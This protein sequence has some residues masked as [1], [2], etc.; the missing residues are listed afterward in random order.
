MAS[1]RAEQLAD[2]LL[3][4]AEK[5]VEGIS[6]SVQKEVTFEIATDDVKLAAQVLVRRRVAVIRDGKVTI[7]INTLPPWLQ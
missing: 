6:G 7:S 4:R 3:R 2:D 5:V 1:E